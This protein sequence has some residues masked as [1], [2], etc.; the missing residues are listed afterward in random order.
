MKRRTGRS[1]SRKKIKMERRI[2]GREND[3]D[4]DEIIK[5]GKRRREKGLRKT[6]KKN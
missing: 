1:E 5:E 6:K 4:D 3:E 2:G